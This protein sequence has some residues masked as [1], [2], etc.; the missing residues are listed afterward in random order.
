M[1]AKKTESLSKTMRAMLVRMHRGS[2]FTRRPGDGR[3]AQG[4]RRTL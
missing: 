1:N 2:G 4:W 3:K